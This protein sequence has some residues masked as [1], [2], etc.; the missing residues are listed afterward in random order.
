M[1]GELAQVQR[2]AL[3]MQGAVAA[4]ANSPPACP[5]PNF[6]R[7]YKSFSYWTFL[8]LTDLYGGNALLFSGA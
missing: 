2:V 4:V 8:D 5:N 7:L 3:H 6:L 1:Q